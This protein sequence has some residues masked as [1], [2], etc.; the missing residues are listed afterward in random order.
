VDYFRYPWRTWGQIQ[1]GVCPGHI[2]SAP[3][4][5]EFESQVLTVSGISQLVCCDY[6]HGDGLLKC[7]KCG[8]SG[9]MFV[10]KLLSSIFSGIIT[11]SV[12]PE[13]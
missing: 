5:L 3:P 4:P 12:A 1:S 11:N 7:K 13:P 2:E 10:R 6:R 9:S 8:I